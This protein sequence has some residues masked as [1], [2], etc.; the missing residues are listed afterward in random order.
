MQLD[1]P[2]LAPLSGG[3]TAQ[4]VILLHGVAANGN[5]L[6]YLARA[7]QKLLPE[8]EFIAPHAPFPCD[9]APEGRQWF[10]LQDRA[11]E[12]LLAGLR[13]AA[14]ILDRFFD[15]LLASRG[16]DDSRLALAGFSQG[17]AT[18]LYTGLHRQK[19]IAGIVAFS[20][21][22]PGGAALQSEIAS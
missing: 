2:G 15:E 6:L 1:G 9:Y 5:D 14:A 18:A 19:Q 4:L 12:K 16:L 13:D 8:A 3:K 17:A 21:A 7:W 11:P 20:G 10:S 22:L